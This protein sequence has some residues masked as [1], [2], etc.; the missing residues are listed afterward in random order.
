MA[1]DSKSSIYLAKTDPPV[2]IKV[3][4]PASPPTF[5]ISL[6]HPKIVH[7]LKHGFFENGCAYW[8]MSYFAGVPLYQKVPK[9]AGLTFSQAWPLFDSLL[10]VISFL[11]ENGIL[12]LDLKPSNILV[13]Q[14]DTIQIID[15]DHAEYASTAAPR[16]R[17]T[18]GYVAPECIVGESP[19]T[20]ASDIYSLGTILAFLLTGKHDATATDAPSQMQNII[21]KAMS[22]RP[23]NRFSSVSELRTCLA[24]G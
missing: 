15:F 4:P 10:D 11:H 9:D 16:S 1:T 18:P 7:L 13:G 2:V 20:A 8:V 6:S 5:L 3:F 24:N 14:K 23:Q 17:G 21:S 19:P 12:H 22:L